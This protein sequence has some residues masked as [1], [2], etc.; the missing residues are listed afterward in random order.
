M[1]AQDQ[2]L[3]TNSVKKFIDNQNVS[4]A[5]RMF[6]ERVETVSHLVAE[7][8]ALA[9]KQYQSRRRGKVAQVIHWDLSGKCVFE[10]T[11]NLFDHKLHPVC[12]S[13]KYKLLW[14]FK[15]ETDQHIEHNKPDIMLLIKEEK[16]CIV[17]DVA[18]PFHTRIMSGGSRWGGSFDG[19]LLNFRAFD[20]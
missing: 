13:E 18:C 12:D 5:C 6:G 3:R 20:D 8:T 16:S 1:A 17:I 2:V 19:W 14:D 9:Q 4:P 10:R 15:I 7:C 11:A